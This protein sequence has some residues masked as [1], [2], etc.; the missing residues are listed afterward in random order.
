MASI[1]KRGDSY[2]I[3]VS[4]GSDLNGKRIRKTVTVTPPEG[5]SE[6]QEKKWLNEQTVLIE[7]K[8][9]QKKQSADNM[10]FE[11]LVTWYFENYAK[12]QLKEITQ[13][14][15]Q[16]VLDFRVLP[17][18]GKKRLRTFNNVMLTEFF[19]QLDATPSVCRTIY[20]ILRSIFS[21]AM[22]MGFIDQHPCDHVILPKAERKLEESKPLLTREQATTLMEMTSEYNYFNFLI[23]FLLFTGMRSGEAFALQWEDIDF[24]NMAIHVRH[25]LTNVAGRHWLDTPKTKSS[26]RRISMS[27]QLRD[28]LLYHREQQKELCEDRRNRQRPFKHPEM[29]FT[30][31]GGNYLDHNYMEKKFKALVEGTDFS[32][33][34]LHGLRHANATL[35]IAGGV[36]IKVVSNLLGHSTISTTA[37][38]YADVLNETKAQAAEGVALQLLA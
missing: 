5:L 32:H 7:R 35:M 9:K 34:T 1:L 3:A 2:Q 38:I 11:E 37:D 26:V 18:L 23:R 14:N 6:L 36:D 27:P 20:V 29:V 17:V 10:F 12:N 28:E 33:L 19:A 8:Y 13:Y 30:G 25:N 31:I 21:C 22:K 24:D 4:C 15:Y 16:H